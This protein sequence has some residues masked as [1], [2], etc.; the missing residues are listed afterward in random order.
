MT[1]QRS[2]KRRAR[3][4]IITGVLMAVVAAATVFVLL[5]AG[6]TTPGQQAVPMRDVVVAT[7]DIAAR[8]VITVDDVTLR[9]VPADDTNLSAFATTEEVVDG[10]SAVAISAGQMITANLLTGT[11]GGPGVGGGEVGPDDPHQRAVSVQVP[12]DRAVGG[13]IQAGQ[14]VDLIATVPI[15]VTTVTTS[16]DGTEAAPAT[17][18][19]GPSTKVTLQNLTVLSLEAADIYILDVDL[20]M[21]EEIAE[22]TAAGGTFTIVLR[23]DGDS[24]T[25]ET[26][27][28][29]LNALLEK[30]DFPIP[31]P[32]ASAERG[33]APAAIPTE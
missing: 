15:E 20:A 27:G 23:P 5:Q 7:R 18:L 30:Y 13:T 19:S 16:E 11:S 1:Q 8:T 2:R 6:G 31:E 17:V 22:L 28:S 3:L 4:I 33:S 25:A 29:T 10:V 12:I 24:R 9:A 14:R 21:A 32:A 26:D